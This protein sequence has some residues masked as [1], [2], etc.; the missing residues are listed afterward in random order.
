MDELERLRDALRSAP[1]ESWVNSALSALDEPS[2][3]FCGK[4]NATTRAGGLVSIYNIRLKHCRERGLP[5]S[6]IESLLD[7]LQH[8]PASAEIFIKPF[9]G[10]TSFVGAF[11]DSNTRLIA[12]IA[13]SRRP[14]EN[15]PEDFKM[16][17]K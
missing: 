3:S 7:A 16:V 17:I 6:G 11:W 9:L 2:M 8:V 1:P 15:L 14:L 12:C 5:C 13:G 10:E 4:S